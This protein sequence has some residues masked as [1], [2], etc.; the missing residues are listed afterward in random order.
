MSEADAV[1]V[2]S[3]P[4]GLAAAVT[5][6]RAGLSVEVYERSDTPGGGLRTLPLLDSDVVHDVCAAVHPM[7]WP[8]RFMRRFDLAARGVRMLRPELAYAHPM[9]EGGAGLAY[10]D[11]ERTCDELGED[12]PRWRRLMEPLVDR[13]RGAADLVLSDLRSLPADPWAAALLGPRV[14]AQRAGGGPLR[15]ERARALLT[16]VAGHVIGPLPSLPGSAVSLLLGHLAHTPGGWPIPEGGSAAVADALVADLL[17]HGGRIRT[18]HEVTDLRE[19]PPA[20]AMLLDVAPRGLLDMGGDLLPD[21]YRA[22]LD[23]FRYAPGAAKADFVVSGPVPWSD[24]DVGRAGTVHLGGTQA[25]MFHAE[26][27]TARGRRVEEPFVLLVDPAVTDPSREV[28]G[29]RPVWAYAHVPNGDPRD[30]VDLVRRR[31]ETFAPGFTDTI[32]AAQGVPAAR[33]AEYNPNH[34]GGD[35]AAGAMTVWQTLARPVPAV[36]PYRT[37]LGGV[38]LCS[39]STPPGP[40]VHGVSGYLAALSALRREFGVRDVPDLAP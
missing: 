28:D 5:L 26:S 29:L 39:S 27:E 7:V 11:L 12:G 16:G 21:R 20:R 15:T 2:G 25:Q 31:I 1:V 10:T 33:M 23:R 6:A 19:L 30:P 17:A 4:N 37:P 22:A 13:G 3:G 38:Y 32:V 40:G 18:G 34:V 14:L 24:H 8:S 35:I 9:P 36:D